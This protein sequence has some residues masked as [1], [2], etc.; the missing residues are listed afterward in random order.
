MPNV[1]GGDSKHPAYDSRKLLK[2]EF[3]EKETL[4]VIRKTKNNV[5]KTVF[6]IY[7]EEVGGKNKEVEV[8]FWWILPQRARSKFYAEIP[9]F[10]NAVLACK[11]KNK[12]K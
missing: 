2:N 11:K 8:G 6:S 9:G 7:Y 10:K 12:K 3:L 5:K 1:M 4:Y